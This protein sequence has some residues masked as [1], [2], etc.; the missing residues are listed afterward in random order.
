MAQLDENYVYGGYHRIPLDK[1]VEVLQGQKYA[2]AVWK[3][4]ETEA[5][6]KQAWKTYKKNK[7]SFK[8]VEKL[9]KKNTNHAKHKDRTAQ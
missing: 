9:V 1:P 6:G 2:G 3:K 8:Y 7:R 4:I 5:Y